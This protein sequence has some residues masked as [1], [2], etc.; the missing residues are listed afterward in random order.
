MKTIFIVQILFLALFVNGQSTQ[1]SE[2][3]DY[4]TNN[5]F[6][7][8][9]KTMQHPAGE[10]HKGVTYVAYQGLLE[11]PYVAAYDHENDQWSG[12][13]KAGESLM[14]KDPEHKIDNHGMPAM[15]IDDEGYI[16]IVFG[17]HGGMPEHGENP[18]GNTHYG[19][20]KHVVSKRPLDITEWEELDNIPPFG[21]YNQFVKMDNGDIYLFYRHG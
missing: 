6:G 1:K 11:D 15:I 12:P 17:G 9:A 16:H 5:G 8:P 13:F 14:G 7:V 2:M 3:V 20:M 4:F 19:A 10:Y 21:T 18:L